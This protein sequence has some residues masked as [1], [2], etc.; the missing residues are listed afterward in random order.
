MNPIL[1]LLGQ[2]PEKN[3]NIYVTDKLA[4]NDIVGTHHDGNKY[5]KRIQGNDNNLNIKQIEGAAPKS[6]QYF[7]KPTYS[8][9]SNDIN[10]KRAI[11][12]TKRSVNPLNPVY[13]VASVAG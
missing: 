12:A 1:K 9:E 13:K 7:N 8:L 4:V 5:I 11:F 10:S 2:T 6:R 3:N